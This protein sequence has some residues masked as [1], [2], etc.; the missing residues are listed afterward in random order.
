VFIKDRKLIYSELFI[1]KRKS[2]E[3]WG[4]GGS[5]HK[6]YSMHLPVKRTWFFLSCTWCKIRKSHITN[7]RYWS[8]SKVRKDIPKVWQNLQILDFNE[9]FSRYAYFL[10]CL[11]IWD[12][13]YLFF[14]FR[15]VF[16]FIFLMLKDFQFHLLFYLY[17]VQIY[18]LYFIMC[19]KSK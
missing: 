9:L 17:F 15:R 18:N 5:W 8:V 11:C 2:M 12:L 14:C 3:N 6:L 7:N 16:Y 1:L 4:G 13:L 10:S 19:N